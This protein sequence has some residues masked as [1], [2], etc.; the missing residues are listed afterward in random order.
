MHPNSM[1][2]TWYG[3]ISDDLMAR[4]QAIKLVIFDVDG[5]FSDGRIYLGNDGEELKAFHTRDGFGVKALLNAGVKVAVITGRKSNIVERRM[6]ALGVTDI[7][8]GQENKLTSY[9]E[10]VAKYNVKDSEVA[11][12]GDDVPDVVMIKAC[13]LGIATNDAH[14]FVMQQAQYVTSKPGGFGAV[15]EVSDLILLSRGQLQLH[16]GVS[17]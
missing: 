12:M 2:N 5:V 10:L 8:Q 16:G 14:P 6:S 9:R 11:C 13:G 4:F 7:Y 3:Q 1:I 17:L 15:R